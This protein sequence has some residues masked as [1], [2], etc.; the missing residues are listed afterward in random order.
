[1]GKIVFGVDVGGTSVKL[2]LFD[3]KGELKKKW[4]IPTRTEDEGANVLPDIAASI[5]ETAEAE[6]YK[7]EDIIGVGIGL[8]GP[9]DSKGVIRKAVNL[10]W[11]RVF[12]VSEELSALLD[13]TKV[14]AGN[15]ANVAALGEAWAGSGKGYENV[16]MV[17]LGTGI[18]GGVIIGGKIITGATGSAGEIGHIHISDEL[19]EKCNCGNSGCLEQFASATGIVRLLEQELAAS[20]EDS[21]MRRE[22]HTAKDMWEAVKAGDALAIRVAEK[23][24]KYLG[25]GLAIIA[26]VVNPDIFIIGGGVSMSGDVIMPYITDNYKKHVFHACADAKFVRAVLGNDGGIYGAC[27]LVLE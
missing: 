8:P 27:K 26:S 21:I 11:N 7:K 3:E 13:G 18:G 14:V 10:H 22:P 6:G 16:V 12:N 19:E 9:V 5:K 4:S 15:D 20:D 2:G 23:F 24:G 17:T 1:M 25:T